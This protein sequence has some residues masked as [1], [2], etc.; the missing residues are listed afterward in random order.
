M[1]TFGQLSLQEGEEVL[2]VAADKG[3]W[4]V[5]SK[6]DGSQGAVPTKIIGMNT[7]YLPD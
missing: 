4:T 1:G 7:A 3:G 6:P 5:V 2:E